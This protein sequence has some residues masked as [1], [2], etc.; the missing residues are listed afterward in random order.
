M[1]LL[2]V[3]LCKA[4]DLVNHDILLEQLKLY[5]CSEKT[6]HWFLSYLSNRKQYVNIRN[7]I[8]EPASVNCGVPQGS[9]F[10]PLLFLVFINDIFLEEH[11]SDICLFADDAVIGRLNKNEIKNKLQPC[12]SSIY[13]WCRQNQMF[14]SI[15]KTNTI[16]ISSKH[17][18][19]S[20]TTCIPTSSVM[21][22]QNELEEVEK[23]KFLGVFIDSTLSWKKTSS[24]CKTM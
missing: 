6:Q 17:K 22:D 13:T 4:F 19:N 8:S 12:G 24:S 11:L 10:G 18:H 20:Q 7:T 3:D 15:E 14:L 1:G 2:L 21:I 9:I 5:K 16:F 23:A